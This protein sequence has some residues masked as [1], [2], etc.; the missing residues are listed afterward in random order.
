[1]L[2][3]WWSTNG[4]HLFVIVGL[5]NCCICLLTPFPLLFWR[6]CLRTGVGNLHLFD[7]TPLPLESHTLCVCVSGIIPP[8]PPPPPPP[9]IR[10]LV[11]EGQIY[12]RDPIGLEYKEESPIVNHELTKSS[13]LKSFSGSR[14]RPYI[15][16]LVVI[17]RS[18]KRLFV[19]LTLGLAGHGVCVWGGGGGAGGTWEGD[20]IG[21]GGQGGGGYWERGYIGGGACRYGEVDMAGCYLNVGLTTLIAG[22]DSCVC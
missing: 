2:M 18:N 5:W 10:S 12:G 7:S 4:G 19:T 6:L 21:E 16:V 20:Y 14:D 3:P 22:S 1:M 8:P 13:L 17:S 15:V 9:H 11:F